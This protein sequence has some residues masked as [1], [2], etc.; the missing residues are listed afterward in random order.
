VNNRQDP[1]LSSGKEVYNVMK[2]I[3]I[4]FDKGVKLIKSDNIW[5]KISIL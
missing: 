4:Q 1:I 5:K 2:D 3:N